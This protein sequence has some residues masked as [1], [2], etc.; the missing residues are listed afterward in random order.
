[1]D[2][3]YRREAKMKLQFVECPDEVIAHKP[4][5]PVKLILMNNAE[6]DEP[7]FYVYSLQ[8]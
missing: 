7:E 4:L 1:M 8:P 3:A 6:G 5:S 2:Q